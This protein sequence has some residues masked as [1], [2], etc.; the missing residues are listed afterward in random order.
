MISVANRIYVKQEYAD[1]LS[2]AF[3]IARVWLIKC[4]GSFRITYCGR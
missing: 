2:S 1:A 4:P 3:A